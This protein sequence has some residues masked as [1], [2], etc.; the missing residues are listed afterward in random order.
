MYV[1]KCGYDF[2]ALFYKLV[3]SDL[4]T[5]TEDVVAPTDTINVTL[6]LPAAYNADDSLLQNTSVVAVCYAVGMGRYDMSYHDDCD[7]RN[8]DLRRGATRCEL[9]DRLFF[10]KDI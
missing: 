2:C 1:F 3:G 4:S 9:V 7:K 8:R 5:R 10:G 6:L